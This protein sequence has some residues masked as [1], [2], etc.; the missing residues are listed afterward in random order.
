MTIPELTFDEIEL[1]KEGL[2]EACKGEF[3]MHETG[4]Y[5]KCEAFQKEAAQIAKEKP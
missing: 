2:C 3:W 1:V 5:E 4:C